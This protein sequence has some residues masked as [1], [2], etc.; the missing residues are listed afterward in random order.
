MFGMAIAITSRRV[1]PPG[2]TLYTGNEQLG[3]YGSFLLV[4]MRF[5]MQRAGCVQPYSCSCLP[6]VPPS[7][8]WD[9]GEGLTAVS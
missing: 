5:L 2:A 8:S 6:Q 9:T 7:G 4:S 1:Q 3:L